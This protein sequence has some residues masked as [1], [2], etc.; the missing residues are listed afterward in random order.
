MKAQGSE[1]SQ[2]KWILNKVRDYA[3]KRRLEAN[4]SRGKGNGMDVDGVD[5][6]EWDNWDP[7]GSQEGN[8]WN[9]GDNGD[10]DALGKGKYGGKGGKKGKGRGRSVATAT[11]VVCLG[12]QPQIKG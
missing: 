2:W 5:W 1:E 3:T 9:G 6:N 11:I 4:L 12:R 10:I 7:W 8:E